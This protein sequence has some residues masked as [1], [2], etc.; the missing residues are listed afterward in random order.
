MKAVRVPRYGGVEVLE[1]IDVDQPRPQA[2]EVLLRVRAAG[3]NYADVLMR[4]GMYP[5]GLKPPFLAGFEIAGEVAEVGE[6]VAPDCIGR[7]VMGMAHSGGYAEY[8]TAMSL[9]TMEL[10]QHFSFEQGAAFPVTY[11]TAYHALVTCGRARQGQ[12]VLIHAAA[13]GVGTAAVQISRLLGLRIIATAS[14]DEKLEKVRAMGAEICVNYAREDFVPI[15]QEATGGRG[16][17]LILESVGGSVF[18]NSF[19]CLAVLGKMVVYGIASG[20][21][22]IAHPRELLF[23]NQSVIG[24]HLT[25]VAQNPELSTP[26]LETLSGWVAEQRLTP[27][28]GHRFPLSEV[29]EAHRLMESRRSYGKIVL[30]P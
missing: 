28:V 4:Y 2:G 15:V 7:R 19:K 29:A 1:Y 21:L 5:G 25:A 14:S 11:Q 10:P 6:G 8:V 22:E 3:I 13:G 30:F 16:C 20:E 27:A 24:L 17:E 18:R 9:A 26:A 23:K 12:F